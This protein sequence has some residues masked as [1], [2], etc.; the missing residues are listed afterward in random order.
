MDLNWIIQL[1]E[2][3]VAI[4]EYACALIKKEKPK[5]A[6]LKANLANCR[7]KK[8]KIFEQK[9][10]FKS[11]I[12]TGI[13]NINNST[14]HFT[15][16][17]S[18]SRCSSTLNRKNEEDG[19]Q[20]DDQNTKHATPSIWLDFHHHIQSN[21]EAFH[22]YSLEANN[23]VRSGKGVS[24]RPYLDRGLYNK[25]ME[26]RSTQEVNAMPEVFHQYI[27]G[28]IDSDNFKAA[29]K[30]IKPLSLLLAMNEDEES[31]NI[32]SLEFLQKLLLEVNK[33]YTCHIDYNSTEDAFNQLFVWPYL[34]VVSKSFT[35]EGI[36]SDFVQGQPC[37]ESMI[38][39]LK[40]VNLYVDDKNQYKADGLIKL[41][42]LNDLELLLLET[43]GCFNNKDKKKLQFDH[44]KGVYGTLAMLKCIVDDYPYASLESFAKVK[45]FFVQAAGD[46][47]HFWSIR[48]Q[49]DGC[50]FDLWREA[51][52]KIKP[53][54]LDKA[55][56]VPDLVQ[57][58]WEM[59]SKLEET[60]RDIL[61]L[62]E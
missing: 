19:E 17:A 52:L 33:A 38:R 41:F 32:S 61:A 7:N 6:A 44:Y 23:I 18:S 45:V 37:L 57:F 34:D 26:A 60:I 43:S 28:Y 59:K 54:F 10:I 22:P 53:N 5:K 25:H 12:T 36:N 39:Q 47:L 13:I 48:Y 27:D 24:P 30:S 50:V 3:P 51:N 62:K 46:E 49:K 2:I 1:E 11:P 14:V 42:G 56:F 29:K 55:D 21:A 8:R 58:F 40:A 9:V 15:N 31:S 35:I 20:E 4:K 16:D